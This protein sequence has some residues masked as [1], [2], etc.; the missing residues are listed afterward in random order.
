L[1]QIEPKV[2]DLLAFLIAMRDRVVSEEDLIAGVWMGSLG[3]G[4]DQ[5]AAGLL[6]ARVRN[7]I[8][9]SPQPFT[10]RATGIAFTAATMTRG[11]EVALSPAARSRRSR[12]CRW[13][14]YLSRVF[15]GVG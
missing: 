3:L 7:E 15:V 12:S 11:V 4:A 8:G 13:R 1:L 6:R 10:K 5:L 2:F 14:K 9:F